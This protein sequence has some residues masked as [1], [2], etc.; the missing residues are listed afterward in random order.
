[1][2]ALLE[3]CVAV[4]IAGGHVASLINRLRLFGL[5]ELIERHTVFAWSA[6]A[7]A[8]SD[9]IVLFHDDPPQGPGASEVLDAGLG[10]V[11]DVV[12]LPQPEKRLRLGDPAR[13][14]LLASRFAPATCLAFPAGAHAVW[15]EGRM[16]RSA[17][18]M[19]LG[20]DGKH[21]LFT[22]AAS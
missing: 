8:L 4:A 7:M 6:A 5:G 19:Q 3:P 20:E 15:R 22:E 1:V 9:R 16:Y 12:A 2:A 21:S 18:V 14:S 13:V 11:H 10:L 17:Q